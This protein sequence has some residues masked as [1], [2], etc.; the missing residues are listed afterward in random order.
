MMMKELIE[1]SSTK[2]SIVPLMKKH[3]ILQFELH[4]NSSVERILTRTMCGQRNS[5]TKFAGMCALHLCLNVG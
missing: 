5:S 2:N 3:Y 4:Q 1:H